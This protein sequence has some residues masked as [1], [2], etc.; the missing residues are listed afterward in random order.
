MFLQCFSFTRF[1]GVYQVYQFI[2]TR[3]I[4]RFTRGYYCTGVPLVYQVYHGVPS[5][6]SP[7]SF[8]THPNA[9]THSETHTMNQPH[10]KADEPHTHKLFLVVLLFLPPLIM[11]E[12]GG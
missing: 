2:N 3:F 10:M 5:S 7:L 9:A 4:T 12:Y 11:V 6:E 8:N 1:N